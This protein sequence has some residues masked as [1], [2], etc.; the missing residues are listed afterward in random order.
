MMAA[1]IIYSYAPLYWLQVGGCTEPQMGVLMTGMG[2]FMA[3]FSLVLPMLSDKIGRKAVIL[4]S[5][6]LAGVTM[7]V[8]FGTPNS[9][10]AIVL[11]V[12]FGGVPAILPLFA[13]S[14]ISVES[15]RPSQCAAAIA[16]VNGTCELLGS[17]MGPLLGGAAADYWGLAAAMLLGGICMILCV[18]VTALMSET[19]PMPVKK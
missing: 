19:L 14:I 16:L 7:L 9:I 17:A 8:L 10:G 5:S 3:I 6:L 12:L 11:F 15:V 18:P 4:P 1:L 2:I 13:M